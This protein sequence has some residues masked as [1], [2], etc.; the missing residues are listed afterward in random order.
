MFKCV[1]KKKWVQTFNSFDIHDQFIGAL[2][3][4]SAKILLIKIR[5]QVKNRIIES[6]K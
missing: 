3:L 6:K 4:L 5:K 2:G 1:E